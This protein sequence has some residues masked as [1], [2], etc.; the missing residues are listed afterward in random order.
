MDADSGIPPYKTIV[1]PELPIPNPSPAA[2]TSTVPTN[3]IITA[4]VEDSVGCLI[5]KSSKQV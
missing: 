5:T 2:A 4:T 3:F 1:G